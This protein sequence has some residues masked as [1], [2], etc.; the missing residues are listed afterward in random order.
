MV[1]AGTADGDGE[2][3]LAFLDVVGQQ[4]VDQLLQLLHKNARLRVAEHKVAHRLIQPAQRPQFLHIEGVGQEAHVKNQVGVQ[5]NA[6]LVAEGHDRD[7]DLPLLPL[8]GKQPEEAVLQHPE[9]EIGAVDHKIRPF[10]DRGQEQLFLLD[11][12]LDAHAGAGERMGTARFLVAAHEGAD[13]GVHVQDAHGAVE[14]GQIVQRVHQLPQTVTLTHVGHQRDALIAAVGVHA[15]LGKARNQR[16]GHVVHAVVIQ[17]LQN[18]RRAA[19]PRAG[20]TGDDKKFHSLSPS[21]Y[22]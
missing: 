10:A 3:Q 15:Q 17:I 11:G 19:L 8:P 1:A 2:T 12:L 20:Q 22:K 5:G 21:V 9:G 18:V 16:H 13:I 14:L 7:L 6:V 4:E